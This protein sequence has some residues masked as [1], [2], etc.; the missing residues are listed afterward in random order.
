MLPTFVFLTDRLGFYIFKCHPGST[1]RN[2]SKVKI[3]LTLIGFK[4]SGN[5]NSLCGPVL[6][7][8]EHFETL[9]KII[10]VW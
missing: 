3:K 1:N 9:T 6:I 7:V 10:V 8:G 5:L 4:I 2:L